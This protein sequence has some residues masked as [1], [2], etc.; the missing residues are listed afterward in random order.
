MQAAS[1]YPIVP[2]VPTKHR[3]CPVPRSRCHGPTRSGGPCRRRDDRLHLARPSA[4][5]RAV[6]P[7]RGEAAM[8]KRIEPGWRNHPGSTLFCVPAIRRYV[9]CLP[10][11][12]SSNQ[13]HPL[14][15]FAQSHAQPSPLWAAGLFA[16]WT[17]PRARADQS[18]RP[19]RP[20]G[21]QESASLPPVIV[22][23]DPESDNPESC[24]DMRNMTP[25][26]G[27]RKNP[28]SGDFL[29]TADGPDGIIMENQVAGPARPTAAFHTYTIVPFKCRAGQE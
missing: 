20:E 13:I 18:T 21:T 8:K 19:S 26:G 16:P 25:P 6:A 9:T 1:E 7:G 22:V 29:L 3:S 11:D 14:P 4:A 23:R 15:P 10:Q 28:E 27:R 5:R 24:E 12:T 2:S 17:S